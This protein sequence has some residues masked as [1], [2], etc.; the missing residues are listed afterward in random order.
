MRTTKICAYSFLYSDGTPLSGGLVR[1]VEADGAAPVNG[2][3]ADGR[4]L[5]YPAVLDEAGSID[6]YL[7]DD[8]QADAQI[9]TEDDILYKVVRRI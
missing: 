6:I 8:V 4:L 3:D 1:L 9:Y 2:Y 7:P 5:P